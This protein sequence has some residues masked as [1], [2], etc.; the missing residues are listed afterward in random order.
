MIMMHSQVKIFVYFYW[1]GIPSR[2]TCDV[3]LGSSMHRAIVGRLSW[4]SHDIGICS[5]ICH[6]NNTSQQIRSDVNFSLISARSRM[7][8]FPLPPSFTRQALV[9]NKINWNCNCL[10]W[11]WNFD[12]WVRLLLQKINVKVQEETETPWWIFIA[13]VPIF[14]CVIPRC[15][16]VLQCLQFPFLFYR[17]K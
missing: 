17:L 13:A 16:F 12:F 4:S 15:L 3:I 6:L 7:C 1:L 14:L 10:F 2:S 11:P 5:F 9:W 8:G